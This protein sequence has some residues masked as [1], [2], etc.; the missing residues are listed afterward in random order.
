MEFVARVW[1]TLWPP[2]RRARRDERKRQPLWTGR[3]HQQETYIQMCTRNPC[4]FMTTCLIL[5]FVWSSGLSHVYWPVVST[6]L[7]SL[8][9]TPLNVAPTAG[10][11]GQRTHSGTRDG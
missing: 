4:V 6:P 3:W 9:A 10:P 1:F 2:T 5:R 11:G 7:S 8:K